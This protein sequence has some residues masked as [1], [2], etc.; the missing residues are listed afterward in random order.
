[1]KLIFL[2][3]GLAGLVAMGSAAQ[4][5]EECAEVP[6]SV[7][8]SVAVDTRDL[9]RP[10]TF[11]IQKVTQPDWFGCW[12]NR[13]WR[14]YQAG[15]LGLAHRYYLSAHRLA[16]KDLDALLGLAAVAARE[17]RIEEA[18]SWYRRALIFDPRNP[19][20][21]AG[22]ALLTGQASSTATEAVLQ[23]QLKKDSKNAG[24]HFALGNLYAR[25]NRWPQAQ[26]A[27]FSALSKDQT[28]PDYAYN[29]AVSL[30]QMGKFNLARRYYQKA[31]QEAQ[32][33]P[34]AFSLGEVKERLQAMEGIDG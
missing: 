17:R 9:I 1:M 12:L 26:K 6:S 22:L 33:R 8:E 30:D 18:Q 10:G 27:Y 23:Q 14:A 2:Y 31:M 24:L 20:A 34:F 16:P 5:R 11:K 21:L 29:L 3:F 28:N 32:L 7:A 19:H 25:Q 13:A 4:A 15:E